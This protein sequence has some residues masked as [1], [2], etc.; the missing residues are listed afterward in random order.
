M[1]QRTIFGN[2]TKAE[3]LWRTSF[4]HPQISWILSVLAV[5]SQNE[6][7]ELLAWTPAPVTQ[8]KIKKYE[9]STL[10]VNLFTLL[11]SVGMT[12]PVDRG[13]GQIQPTK[14]L[15]FRYITKYCSLEHSFF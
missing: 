2:G 8:K 15:C 10:S 11:H 13:C 4:T 1:L 6:S 5:I 12:T 14:V 9:H 3:Y 7:E